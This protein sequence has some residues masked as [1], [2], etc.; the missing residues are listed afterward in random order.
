[1]SRSAARKRNSRRRRRRRGSGVFVTLLC[2]VLI[3]AAVLAA[4]TIFFKVRTVTVIGDSRYTRDEIAAA[5]GIEPGQNM[6]ML[7]KFAAISRIFAACP[8]LDEIVMRRRLPDEIEITVTECVPAAAIETAEGCY[9]IDADCKLL[10]LTDKAGAAGYC[11]VTGVELDEPEVGKTAN[12]TQPEKQKPLQTILNTAQI[13]DILD[14][15]K[16]INLDQIFEIELSYAGRFTVQLG[17]VE[18]LEKKVRFL[19]VCI[20]DLGPE[21]RGVIDVSDPQTARFRPYKQ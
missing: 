4:M 16:E 5:S 14:E 7:N 21:E 13:N 19:G 3:L 12:F 6:F 17:T 9:I 15:I 1:M 20:A 2:I 8:Y 10:E 18:E 11:L